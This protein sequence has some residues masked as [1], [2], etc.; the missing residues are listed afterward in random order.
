MVYASV[1]KE[2]GA[3]E[4][5]YVSVDGGTD[6]RII[7][8][9]GTATLNIFGH[10]VEVGSGQGLY[11]N[12]ITVFPDNPYRVLLG[13]IN[14][15]E[16]QQF[17][18]SG[19]YQ[20]NERSSP[21]NFFGEGLH[22]DQHNIVFRPGF[23]DQFIVSNDGGVY[24][25]VI[26]SNLYEFTSASKTYYSAQYYTAAYSGRK[27]KVIGG[28]QDNGVLTISAYGPWATIKNANDLPLFG[29]DGGYSF[30]SSINQEAMIASSHTIGDVS[31][32]RTDDDAESYSNSFLAGEITI[33]DNTFLLTSYLWEDFENENSRDSIFFFSRQNSYDAGD[34]VPLFSKNLEYPFYYN[35]PYALGPNDSILVKDV[36]STKFF[37]AVTDEL[38]MTTQAMDFT[39]LPP[40]WFLISNR[41]LV[42]FEGNPESIAVSKDG[43]TAW[44]G[45]QDGKLYRISN[46]ALA[47][48]Y[49]RADVRSPYCQISTTI[50]PVYVPGTSTEITQAITSIAIDPNDSRHV[51]ITLGNYGNSTYVL[52]STNGLAQVPEF[53]SAQGNLPKMP[54]YASVIEM[55]NPNMVIIGSEFGAFV[56]NN[57]W[58]SSPAWEVALDENDEAIGETPV[59]MLAQQ[60]IAQEDVPI[61][62]YDGIDST[63]EWYAGTDNFGVIYAASHGRGLFFTDHFQ[64]PVGIGE[65]LPGNTS[66]SNMMVYPNPVRDY[67]Q[68]DFELQESVNVQIYVYDINGRIITQEDLSKQPAGLLHYKIGCADLPAG[69]YFLRLIAGKTMKSTKFVVYK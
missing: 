5:I 49:D 38:W 6:W 62:N 59:F 25:A 31:I 33:P 43:N 13:G 63:L 16:G 12:C 21:N 66:T 17:T 14:L 46:I 67:A 48:D 44:V 57:V 24:S 18:P 61:W 4:N 29:G 39:A 19:F 41:N 27:Y 37:L 55:N 65:P 58:D 7:A 22:E 3:L 47:Y 28:T 50:V 34:P 51:I 64:Q 52:K 54:V 36:V 68:L 40:E 9:G 35:L 23:N 2:S 20:W 11:D 69:T 10:G 8:P 45:T 32:R 53:T 15:W 26:G 42:G 56:C 60:T 1:A 30:I